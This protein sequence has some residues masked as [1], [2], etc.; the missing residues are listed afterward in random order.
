MCVALSELSRV[1][2]VLPGVRSAIRNVLERNHIWRH[3][4]TTWPQIQFD[5]P[6]AKRSVYCL[7]LQIVDWTIILKHFLFFSE[8]LEEHADLRIRTCVYLEDHSRLLISIFHVEVKNVA[9]RE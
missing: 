3:L 8:L 9:G 6:E 5:I 7:D 2:V 1:L 4:R